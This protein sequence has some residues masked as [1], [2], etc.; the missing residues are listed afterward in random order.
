MAGLASQWHSMGISSLGLYWH[1][2]FTLLVAL[3]GKS[4][5][6]QSGPLMALSARPRYAAHRPHRHC[7]ENLK[8]V[9]LN[10]DMAL[11]GNLGHNSMGCMGSMPAWAQSGICWGQTCGSGPPMALHCEPKHTNLGLQWHTILSLN[12]PVWASHGT[13]F[14]A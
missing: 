5:K 9:G 6:G 3:Y 4:Q 12:T 10:L 14:W 13:T 11:Y 7:I 2:L 1:C 8:E